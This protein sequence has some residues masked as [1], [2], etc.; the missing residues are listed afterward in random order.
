[1]EGCISAVEVTPQ[2]GDER[3]FLRHIL[4][5]PKK[6]RPYRRMTKEIPSGARVH[7]KIRKRLMFSD[8]EDHEREEIEEISSNSPERKEDFDKVMNDYKSSKTPESSEDSERSRPH[9]DGLMAMDVRVGQLK[10][11]QNGGRNADHQRIKRKLA[12]S[13]VR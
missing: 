1:M 12:L 2:I 7:S 10:M 9:I 6:K 4:W 5:A 3:A 8:V 13:S 11:S